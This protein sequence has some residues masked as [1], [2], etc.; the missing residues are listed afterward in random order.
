VFTERRVTRE[1]R[2]IM[3][4]SPFRRETESIPGCYLEKGRL[5]A[6]HALAMITI[7]QVTQFGRAAIMSSVPPGTLLL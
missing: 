6:V 5:L 3:R 2:R 4:S 1:L 7:V